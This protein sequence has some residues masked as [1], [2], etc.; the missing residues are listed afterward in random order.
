METPTDRSFLD[1]SAVARLMRLPLRS[2]LPMQGNMSGQHKS[3]HRGSS[4]EFAEYRKYAPGDDIRRLDWRVYARSDR[5]YIKE[6]EAD[7][8]LRCYMVLDCSASMAFAAKH[9]TKHDFARKLL[10]MLAYL[11]VHQGDA[12]GLHAFAEDVVREIPTRRNASHL[13]NIFDA[14]VEI[15]PAGRTQLVP[16]LHAFAEKIRQRA[17]VVVFSDFFCEV[18]PLL[19]CFQHLRFRHHDLAVFHILDRAELDFQFDRPIRFVD[20]E[21]PFSL[22]TEPTLI[23][24]QYLRELNT[25]LDRLED[26][27]HEFK[28]DYRRVVTDQNPEDILA[29]FLLD[30]SR[31]K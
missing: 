27:C 16:V 8:N 7:T 5:F 2:R 1:P 9:G 24:N 30:R 13:R 21:S 3:I 6:F 26:G 31:N 14:L 18:E 12:V 28:A 10:A 23:R 19:D 29:S 17:L 25:H 15:E 20:M 4:V 22:V 11:V